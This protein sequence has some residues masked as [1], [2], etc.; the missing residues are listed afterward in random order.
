M[1][2]H[3]YRLWLMH[4]SRILVAASVYRHTHTH[5]H[6]HTRLTALCPGPPGWAGTRK[7]KAILHFTEARDGEWQWHQLGHMQV[8]TSLR[9]DNHAS[10]HHSVIYRPDVL[11]TSQPTASKHWRLCIGLYY[12][13]S[14]A[15]RVTISRQWKKTN[16]AFGSHKLVHSQLGMPKTICYLKQPFGFHISHFKCAKF[17]IKIITSSRFLAALLI[18]I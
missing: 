3:A 7:V 17:C 4:N 5:T 6:T 8:C 14:I 11:P 18:K 10:S 15:D 16:P 9:T 12:Y 2:W 1:R 13:F